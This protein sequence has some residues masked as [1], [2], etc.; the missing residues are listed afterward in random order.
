MASSR[1]R[2]SRPLSPISSE[3]DVSAVPPGSYLLFTRVVWQAAVG[4]TVV[5][6]G[7]WLYE[8]VGVSP[9]STQ[10]IIPKRKSP[11]RY[12]RPPF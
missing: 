10:K 11:A 8:T 5:P 12:L 7:G 1:P 9:G 6:Q 3:P 2:L 4:T